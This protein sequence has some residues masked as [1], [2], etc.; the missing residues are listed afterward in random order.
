M[1]NSNLWQWREHADPPLAEIQKRVWLL[2]SPLVCMLISRKILEVAQG[3][4]YIH[5]EGIV[6][7]DICGVSYLI[8]ACFRF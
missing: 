3:L 7:G 2:L 1:Q 6:H 5:S 4:E 8:T